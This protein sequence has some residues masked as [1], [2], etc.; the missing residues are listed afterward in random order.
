[1]GRGAAVVASLASGAAAS[2][3]L[4]APWGNPFRHRPPGGGVRVDYPTPPGVHR[5]RSDFMM[6]PTMASSARASN[7]HRCARVRAP[8]SARRQ[9]LANLRRC[10]LLSAFGADGSGQ[11]QHGGTL[12]HTQ[13]REQH[14]LP[15]R[16]LKRIVMGHRV[17]QVDLPEAREPLPYLLVWPKADAEKGKGARGGSWKPSG[18]RE[19]DWGRQR[20]RESDG[21]PTDTASSC[22]S[23]TLTR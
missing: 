21:P 17:V 14:H 3:A 22:L 23:K 5:Y 10:L 6:P 13:T 18:R 9:R 19:E 2:V 12:A 8:A 16:E 7:S 20:S 4:A 15:V 1:M 11:L